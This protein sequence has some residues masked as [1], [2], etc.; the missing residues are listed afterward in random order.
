MT[1][2][3]YIR[4]GVWLMAAVLMLSCKKEAKNTENLIGSR[5]DT[6][7]IEASAME[8]GKYLYQKEGDTISLQLQVKDSKVTGELVYKLKEKDANT[9]TIEGEIK[10]NIIIALYTFQSEG[11][12]SVRQVAFKFTDKGVVEG[13][14][15]VEEKEGKVLFKDINTLNYTDEMILLKQ[16]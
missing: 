6:T 11:T 1:Y 9:G 15:A 7:R 13:Y 8:S 5:T 3:N 10:D 12:T 4:K 14:G 2:Y 16:N